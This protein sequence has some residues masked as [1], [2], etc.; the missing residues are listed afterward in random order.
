MSISIETYYSGGWYNYN[1]E[2]LCSNLCKLNGKSV[3]KKNWVRAW[4]FQHWVSVSI[5]GEAA[6]QILTSSWELSYG[7]LPGQ[8]SA[9][10]N[11]PSRNLWS[12]LKNLHIQ[13]GNG[14][15]CKI[16]V[17]PRVKSFKKIYFSLS[18]K[19]VSI[20]RVL[21]YDINNWDEHLVAFDNGLP[22]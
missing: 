8:F 21:K 6:F 7:D 3:A 2:V 19:L 9:V 10:A 13:D 14:P 15:P 11:K 12:I 18:R 17:H 20:I 4:W 1:R 16:G 5:T 22:L